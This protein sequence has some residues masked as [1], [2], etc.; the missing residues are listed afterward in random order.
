MKRSAKKSGSFAIVRKAGASLR[1]GTTSSRKRRSVRLDGRHRKS[2]RPWRRWNRV[3]GRK[4]NARFP[5]SI[6]LLPASYRRF[7]FLMIRHSKSVGIRKSRWRQCRGSSSSN[8]E[9]S[10]LKLRS[11]RYHRVPLL[12]GSSLI[13]RRVS[14]SARYRTCRKTWH[15]LCRL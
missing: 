10:I 14:K 12:Q 1:R 6:H 7:R 5:C 8:C 4:K 15:G 13:R 3:N 9:I 2:S 11:C